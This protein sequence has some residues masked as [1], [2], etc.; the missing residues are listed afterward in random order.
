MFKLEEH[1]TIDRPIFIA[2][3][4]RNTNKIKLK[5]NKLNKTTK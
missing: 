2:E 4:K 3:D 1:F 5:I